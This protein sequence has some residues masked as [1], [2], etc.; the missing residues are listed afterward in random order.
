MSPVP[1]WIRRSALWGAAVAFA[2][3][4]LI[5]AFRTLTAAPSVAWLGWGTT[6][7]P[8]DRGAVALTFDDGLNGRYTLAV[9]EVLEQH[10]ATGTFFVVGRTLAEQP[11]VARALLDRGHLLANHS[12]QHRYA[13]IADPRY[14]ELAR[15]ETAFANTTGRCPRFFR[16]PHGSHT[17]FMAAAVR[18]AR[19]RLVNWDVEV[20]DWDANDPDRLAERVLRAVRPGSIVLLHDGRDGRPGADRS[21]VVAAL[22]RILQGLQ[23]R[24][25]RVVRLDDLLGTTG[26]LDRCP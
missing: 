25:L 26:Y 3:V 13:S 16:P 21:V 6:H 19:M 9:A 5:A 17:P 24:G 4:A 12:Y 23:E 1:R 10:G 22:P 15:A 14:A 7:G 18:R 8:R 20:R 2:I 11:E